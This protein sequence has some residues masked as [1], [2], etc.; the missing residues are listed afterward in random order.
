M[1]GRRR[2]DGLEV[3]RGEEPLTCPYTGAPVE[4]YFDS[5]LRNPGWRARGLFDPALPFF[6]KEAGEAAFRRRRGVADAVSLPVCAYTGGQV[7]F[8]RR[9]DLWY[10]VGG[11]FRPCD[12]FYTREELEDGL[13]AR[14]GRP[15]PRRPKRPR[16]EVGEVAEPRSDTVAG[17]SMPLS[18]ARDMLEGV[19]R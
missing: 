12:S 5:S 17:L 7:A 13:R 14:P 11:F 10:A 3:P 4:V 9:G 2:R 16:V 6:S 8:E 1:A 18:D 19:V 15:V